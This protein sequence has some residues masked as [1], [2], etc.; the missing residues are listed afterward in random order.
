[1]TYP[2]LGAGEQGYRNQSGARYRNSGNAMRWRMFLQQ[3]GDGNE[4]NVHGERH[5]T[6][7]HDSER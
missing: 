2:L 1:M 4:S 6:G 5:K 3:V 7:T